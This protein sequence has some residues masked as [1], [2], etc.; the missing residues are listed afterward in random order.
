MKPLNLF[1][2]IIFSLLISVGLVNAVGT[3][4]AVD[5]NIFGGII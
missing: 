2:L 1:T 3:Y 4:P 5:P